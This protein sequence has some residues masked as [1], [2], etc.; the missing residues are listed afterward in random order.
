MNRIVLICNGFDLP[1]GFSYTLLGL[2]RG[3][4]A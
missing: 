3:K 1:H 2:R 4:N